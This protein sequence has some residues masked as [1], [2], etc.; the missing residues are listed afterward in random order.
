M[1]NAS[2]SM[3]SF[4]LERLLRWITS[5]FQNHRLLGTVWVMNPSSRDTRYAS[6]FFAG[7][8]HGTRS[9]VATLLVQFSRTPGRQQSQLL[10]SQ[11]SKL[12]VLVARSSTTTVPSGFI[13]SV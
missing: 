8:G 4:A 11:W 7:P 3:S 6:H 9:V 13:D 12:W 1:A 5:N 2:N 10:K